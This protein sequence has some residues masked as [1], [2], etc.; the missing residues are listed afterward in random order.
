MAQLQGWPVPRLRRVLRDPGPFRLC[1]A[2]LD[3]GFVLGLLTRRRQWLQTSH[4]GDKMQREQTD[5]RSHWSFQSE[6][7]FLRS[8]LADLAFHVIGQNWVT[9]P[10]LNQSL[11]RNGIS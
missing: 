3:T 11:W 7:T 5:H 1:S 6:E 10:F 2:N 4:P 8:T 9:C